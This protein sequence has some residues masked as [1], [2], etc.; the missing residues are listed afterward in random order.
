MDRKRVLNA[1]LALW[2]VLALL[3]CAG[4]GGA[5]PRQLAP[6][7]PGGSVAP[8]GS[9]AFPA[10]PA[11]STLR[12]ASAVTSGVFRY[13]RQFESAWPNQL[14]TADG[15][16]LGF[17]PAWPGGGGLG[18]A[19]FALYAFDST[20]YHAV[21]NKLRLVWQQH[22]ANSKDLWIGLANFT[23]DRWDWFTEPVEGPL[24]YDRVHYTYLGK[25][26]A[27][28]VILGADD[29]ELKSI[30]ICEGTPPVVLNI[31]PVFVNQGVPVTITATLDGIADTFLWSFGGAGTPNIS[32]NFSP[33]L[34]PGVPGDYNASLTVSNPCGQDMVE[35]VMHVLVPPGQG[36]WTMFGR[37]PTHNRRSPYVAAQTSNLQWSYTTGDGLYSSPVLGADGTVYVGSNDKH[38]YAFYPDGSLRWS[39]PTGDWVWGSPTLG[40]DGTVYVGS[41]DGKLYAISPTGYLLWA[42]Q[43]GNWVRSSPAV[44]ADGTIYVG[45]RDRKLYAINQDGSLKWSYKT[46]DAVDS[47]PALAADGTIYIGSDDFYLY[48]MHPDGTLRWRYL[49]GDM[50][51][52]APA[53]A[54]DGTVYVGSYDD[55]LYALNPDGTLKWAYLTGFKVGSSPAI[56]PDGTVYVG[57][58]DKKLYA[59]NPDGSLNWSFPTGGEIRSSPALAADGTVYFGSNDYS[60]YAVGAGGALKWQSAT[61]WYVWSSP[62][63]GADGR[64]YVGSYDGKIY[65]FGP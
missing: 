37:E 55:K 14:V 63:I 43:T 64:V 26:Y 29:W 40:V 7:T 62:A 52:S 22:G 30:R 54:E 5:G 56:G 24:A 20:G 32:S 49:T 57:S 65:A 41:F 45:S 25:V 1:L 60:V 35:F 6:D 48:A 47:S 34:T 38:L 2:V 50:V 31:A 46:G 21:D 13:G 33:G 58:Y 51:W 17:A 28:V 42:F 23:R 36:D 3:G 53:I 19:A 12:Q 44:G 9:G 4:G 18:G 39:Y 59:L 27:A 10:L 61:L 15:D 16:L 8:A 11:P